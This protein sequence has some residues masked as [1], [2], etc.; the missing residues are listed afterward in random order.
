M[1]NKIA[2]PAG[3]WRGRF[4]LLLLASLFF[5]PL[6]LASI[7]YSHA[8]RWPLPRQRANHGELIS[9]PRS[10]TGLPLQDLQGRPLASNSLRGRWSLVYPGLPV[11]DAGCEHFLYQIRQVRTAL[12]K[13]INRVQRIYLLPEVPADPA[14]LEALRRLHPD[15]LFAVLASPSTMGTFPEADPA[16]LWSGRQLFVVD[17]LENLMMR[18]HADQDPKGVLADLKRLL[19]IS[20]IG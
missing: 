2:R 19:R 14:P 5:G 16:L 8:D 12:G 1:T 20:R 15:L 9:P 7:W 18:Y 17:P 11:C 13:D 4:M 6:L 10:M 3:Q